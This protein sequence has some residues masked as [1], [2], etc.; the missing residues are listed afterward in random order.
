M[1]VRCMVASLLLMQASFA[2]TEDPQS[3]SSTLIAP[4]EFHS[5]FWINLHHFLYQQALQ[6]ANRSRSPAPVERQTLS[7]ESVKSLSSAPLDG[8]LRTQ[9]EAAATA[10]S[11]RRKTASMRGLVGTA[12]KVPCNCFGLHI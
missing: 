3:S 1:I 6:K 10:N 7:A 2:G 12:M 11:T 5:A 9:L 4:F 8:D